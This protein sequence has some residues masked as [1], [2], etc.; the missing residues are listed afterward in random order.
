MS[1]PFFKIENLI[2]NLNQITVISD[3]TLGG[4]IQWEVRLACGRAYLFNEER[5]KLLNEALNAF[6]QK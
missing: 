6:Y 2:I 5:A 1:S 3:Q 4:A